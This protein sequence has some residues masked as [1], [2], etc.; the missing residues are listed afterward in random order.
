MKR[1]LM[2]ASVASMIYQFNMDNID[3]LQSLGYQVD[4]A[5][6]F[7]K[8]NPISGKQI[9]DFK[10]RLSEKNVG[11]IETECLRDVF[12]IG[13]MFRGY[14]QLKRL[15]GQREYGLVHTQSPIG[16]A[17][18]RLAFRTARR[19]GTKIIYTAHGFH[20]YDGAPKKNWLVFYPVEKWLSRWTDVLITINKEDYGRAKSK[21]HAKETVY[22]P[23]VGIDTEK[24]IRNRLTEEEIKKIKNSIGVPEGYIWFLSVGELNANKNHEIVI[25]ALA[26][27]VKKFK[28]FYTVAGQGNMGDELEKLV[29]SL[30]IRK[31]VKL[32]GFR[33]DL[34]ELYEAADVYI[35]PSFR[36][37]L[38]V[39]LMEAMASGLPCIASRIRG[40]MDL[41]DE[42]KG[43]YLFAPDGLEE[44]EGTVKKIL[45]VKREKLGEYNRKRIKDFQI[46]TVIEK[47]EKIYEEMGK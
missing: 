33:E 40:N 35:H 47:I 39:A 15:A 10:Q 9:E 5:C 1:A 45:R 16:G 43:G 30:G 23:G 17:I 2:H 41:I 36:E 12:A 22:I 14:R 7:G 18:C 25:R 4:V 8:S 19:R 3:L 20:F 13:K 32:L 38:P 26:E 46:E 27:L 37:G 21:F 28:I 42:G 44:F 24:F 11:I 29:D 34:P 31:N 6:N